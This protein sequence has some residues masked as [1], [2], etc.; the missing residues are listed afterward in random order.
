M[1]MPVDESGRF[2]DDYGWPHGLGTIESAD[3]TLGN[4]GERGLLVEA[5]LY[6]HRHPHCWRFVTPPFLTILADRPVAVQD[7]AQPPPQPN[8]H[9]QARI[10]SF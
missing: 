7:L 2:Y 5:G 9:A 6:E 3:Q 10:P 1:L 8:A 4:L